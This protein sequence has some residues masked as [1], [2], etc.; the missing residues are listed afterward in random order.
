MNYKQSVNVFLPATQYQ[1]IKALSR[2]LDL[3]YSELIRRG[4]VLVLKKYQR[5][6]SGAENS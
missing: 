5:K 4:V 3:P 2:K 1:E 6:E